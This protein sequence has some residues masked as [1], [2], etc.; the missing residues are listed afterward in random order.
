MESAAAGEVSLITGVDDFPSE[1][2]ARNDLATF[3][4]NTHSVAWN[5][6]DT[7]ISAYAQHRPDSDDPP[8]LFLCRLC[9]ISQI[10]FLCA[11]NLFI[12]DGCVLFSA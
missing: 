12:F 2:Y 11:I 5:R 8:V 7:T 10:W 9:L 3:K 6:A 1:I 4:P